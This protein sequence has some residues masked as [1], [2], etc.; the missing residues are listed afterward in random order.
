M[1]VSTGNVVRTYN[2][3]DGDLTVTLARVLGGC[4]G[5]SSVR[6]V[7]VT[8]VGVRTSPVGSRMQQTANKCT[9]DRTSQRDQG[10][11]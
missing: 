4:P 6:Y 5:E 9:S 11:E 10:S 1:S 7:R 3:G 8:A 2:R